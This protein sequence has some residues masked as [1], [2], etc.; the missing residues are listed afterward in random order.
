MYRVEKLDQK[1]REKM[2]A[3]PKGWTVKDVVGKKVIIT[4]YYWNEP[5][6]GTIV[7][8]YEKHSTWFFQLEGMNRPS[9]M[10][11]EVSM[12]QITLA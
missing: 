1:K 2:K 8:W 9:D 5:V 6:L 12:S 11:Y 4:S 7:G 10:T 3:M